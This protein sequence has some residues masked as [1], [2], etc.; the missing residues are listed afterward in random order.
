MLT[1]IYHMKRMCLLGMTTALLSLC[2]VSGGLTLQPRNALY[3]TAMASPLGLY[4]HQFHLNQPW[5]FIVPR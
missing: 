4:P 1:S 2:L 3:M 5:S